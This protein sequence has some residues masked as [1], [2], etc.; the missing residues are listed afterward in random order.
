MICCD[1]HSVALIIT[2]QEQMGP[3]RFSET[4]PDI[5]VSCM[6]SLLAKGPLSVNNTEKGTKSRKV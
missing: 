1:V 6:L 2:V 5:F 4:E 3:N